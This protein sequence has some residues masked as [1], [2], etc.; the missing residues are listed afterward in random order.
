MGGYGGSEDLSWKHQTYL[1]FAHFGQ[2]GTKV[3]S[4]SET[5][6]ETQARMGNPSSA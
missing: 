5:T 2:L 1:P 4:W 3:V 6:V